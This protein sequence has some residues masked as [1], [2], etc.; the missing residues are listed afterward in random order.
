MYEYLK[1]TH[2]DIYR[3]ACAVQ[4]LHT[5]TLMLDDLPCTDNSDYRRK[6]LSSHKK[7]GEAD[8]TLVAFGLANEAFAILSD[9]RNLEGLCQSE[10]LKV[11]HE[12]T[13]KVG[14]N[15]LVRGQMADLDNGR[16][17]ACCKDDKGL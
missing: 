4:L 15:G 9:V 5:A 7:F 16:R 2:G 6:K 17:L 11:M 13:H 1:G 14:F 10:A 3:C 12:I 8:T